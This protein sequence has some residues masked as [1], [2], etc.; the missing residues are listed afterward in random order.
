MLA[1]YLGNSETIDAIIDLI[2]RVKELHPKMTVLVDPVMG[3]DGKLYVSNELV[4]NYPRLIKMASIITPNGFEA[5]V[6]SGIKVENKSVDRVFDKLHALGPN[7]VVITSVI[8][9]GICS[10]YGSTTVNPKTRFLIEIE[11]IPQH[12]TGTGIKINR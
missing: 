10:L 9:N 6:L 11:L 3:D 7:T 8:E 12:F 4:L 2:T 1:G 5:E